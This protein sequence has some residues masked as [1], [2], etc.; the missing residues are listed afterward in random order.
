MVAIQKLQVRITKYLMYMYERHRCI[1][2]PNMKFL[3]LNLWL[4][5][6]CS[7]DANADNETNDDD[8]RRTKY[9]WLISQMSQKL[10]IK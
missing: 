2:I 9:D 4:E 7:D 8:T 3:C 6:V 10:Y 1:C 5:E